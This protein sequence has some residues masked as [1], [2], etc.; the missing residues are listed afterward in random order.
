MSG[1]RVFSIVDSIQAEIIAISDYIHAN[2]E[3]GH[4]EVK[5]AQYLVEQLQTAGFTVEVGAGG[6]PTAFKAVY[7][8]KVA[9]PTVAICAEYDALPGIGHAC[10]HNVIAAAACGAGWRCG[11]CWIMT[12][13]GQSS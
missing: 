6:F 1:E 4:Q 2:P 10:G 5:S 9:G 8:G 3:I 7:Q 12:C 11:S 13:R